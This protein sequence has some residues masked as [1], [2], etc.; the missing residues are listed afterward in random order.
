MLEIVVILK[1]VIFVERAV[2]FEMIIER[3]GIFEIV[4]LEIVVAG[5]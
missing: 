4:I 3:V 2:L 5:K 1:I